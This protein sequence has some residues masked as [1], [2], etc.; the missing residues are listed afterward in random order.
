MAKHR[1][2]PPNKKITKLRLNICGLDNSLFN[3]IFIK[4]LIITQKLFA[5]T[6]IRRIFKFKTTFVN[7]YGLLLNRLY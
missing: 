1:E 7:L 3:S 4:D 5:S 2:K 6:Q